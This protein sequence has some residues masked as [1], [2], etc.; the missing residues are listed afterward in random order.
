MDKKK[1]D[2]TENIIDT[3]NFLPD[4]TEGKKEK[5]KITYKAEKKADKDEFIQPDFDMEV[6][7]FIGKKRLQKKQKRR[8]VT[9]AVMFFL[10]VVGVVSIVMSGVGFAAKLLDNTGEKQEYNALLATLVVSDPLPFESPDLADRDWLLSSSVW[11]A[12]MN[13]DMSTYEQNDFGETYLPAVEVDKYYTR[14]FGTQYPLQHGTFSDQEIEFTYDEEKQAYIVP[15]TSFPTGF[16]PEVAKIKKGSG[17][18]IVTVGYISPATSWTDTAAGG[19]SKYVDYIFQKQGQEYYLVAI[20]E[21][22]M[23]VEIPVTE[24]QAQ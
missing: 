6:E 17:E 21:S 8:V 12:V 7:E 20:R 23:Q 16:T 9:G 19:V 2:I 4:D 18:K 10:M 22:E 24:S 13:S 11:A 5:A 14:V 15:V 3:E 1:I